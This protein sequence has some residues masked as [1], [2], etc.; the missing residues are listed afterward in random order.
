MG[1][2]DI[3]IFDIIVFAVIAI[4]LVFRLKSVLVKRTGFEKTINNKTSPQAIKKETKM[5]MSRKS[6]LA[7]I[8][9]DKVI[10]IL[11]AKADLVFRK[12]KPHHDIKYISLVGG[13]AANKSIRKSF[14][15]ICKKNNYRLIAPPI[16]LCGDNAAM[17]ALACIEKVNKKISPDLNFVADPR[18]K[19]NQT[20]IK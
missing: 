11:I 1:Y 5:S 15:K 3:Q 17:I 8:F 4:F 14:E 18:L 13:V 9:Q 2:G 7:K 12:L 16:N 19:I 10:E 20:F 6:S